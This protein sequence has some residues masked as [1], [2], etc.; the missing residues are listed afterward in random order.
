MNTA[1]EVVAPRMQ[2]LQKL[3]KSLKRLDLSWKVIETTARV[4]SPPESAGFIA[5]LEHTR[6]AFSQLSGEMVEQI[7]KT[8]MANCQHDLASRAQVA[9]DILVRNLFERTADVGFIATD[10]P[11]VNFVLAPAD[12]SRERLHARLTE[13]RN[14]YTVYDDILVLDASAQ[15]LLALKARNAEHTESP[16]WWGQAMAQGGYVE[17]FGLSGLFRNAGNVLLYAHRIT[18]PEGAVCGA[19][20]LKFDLQSELLSI[21]KTLHTAHHCILLRDEKGRVV[22]CSDASFEPTDVV[23]LSDAAQSTGLMQHHGVDYLVAHCRTRGYQGYGGPGWTALALV[24]LD[25]AFDAEANETAAGALSAADSGVEIEL[26]NAELHQIIGRARAIEEDLNRVIWNGKLQASST[27]SN[28]ALGPVF[29]EIGRT[30]QQTIAAFEDAIREL[31]LLLLQGRR[32]ELATQAAL[33]VDIM[34]RNLYERAND[35]RWWALSEEFASLLQTLEAGV[36]DAAVQR[37]AEMLAHLNSLYTVYRRVALFDRQGRIIAVSRDP[38]SLAADCAIPAGL[39]QKTLALKGTQAYAVSAM[40]PHALADGEATYLYCAPIRLAGSERSLGGMALAFNCREELQTMLQDSLPAGASAL[41]IYVDPAGRVLASTDASMVVGDAPDFVRGL[42]L[43]AADAGAGQARVCQWQGRSYLVGLACS[44][45]Y[46]EFKTSDGYR[47]EVQSVLLSA[48]DSAAQGPSS[49]TLP[50]ASPG[51]GSAQFGVV[52]CGSMLFALSGTQVVE[53]V[54]ATGLDAPVAASTMSGVLKLMLNGELVLLPAYDCCKLTGQT[55]M[56]DPTAAVAIVVH[57]AQRPLALLVDRL[58]DVIVCDTL[59][60]PP[61]GV[62][63]DTPWI[64]GYLHDQLA[65]T[66]PVFVLDPASFDLGPRQSGDGVT[67][68]A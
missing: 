65:H 44:Q 57:G 68:L 33:A 63:P 37:A 67:P 32:A 35:C 18:S 49:F 11:L 31:K 25:E 46:R 1:K 16:D 19:V 24:R 53:A 10:A 40:S 13:Y 60:A 2:A 4:V 20:V 17:A 62:N 42:Q 28:A 51:A 15:I 64:I 29:A 36:S 39:L 26:N 56:A 55:P 54:S 5:T 66:Q 6:A 12:H 21:F 22:A 7:A 50:Q 8:H 30:S 48:V 34:D 3:E 45:G 58:V 43:G 14:K 41:G 23:E 27:S 59:A 9:I 38:Q 61:G 52:Q 47:E